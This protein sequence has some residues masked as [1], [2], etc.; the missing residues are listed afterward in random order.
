MA[1]SLPE[2]LSWGPSTLTGKALTTFQT[3]TGW[4]SSLRRLITRLRRFTVLSLTVLS[5]PKNSLSPL[6]TPRFR[7]MFVNLRRPGILMDE[8]SGNEPSRYSMAWFS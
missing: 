7:V 5:Q 1:T 4:C 2:A 6:L 3:I 8:Y